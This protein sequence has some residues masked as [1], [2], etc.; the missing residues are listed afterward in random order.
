MEMA[1]FRIWNKARTGA[2]IKADM[3]RILTG[4]EAGLTAYYTFAN[5][6]RDITGHGN[7]GIFMYKE[8]FVATM[9]VLAGQVLNTEGLTSIANAT[10]KATKGA[11]SYTTT[12][13]TN[14][15]FTFA[16][17]PAGDYVIEVVTNAYYSTQG[18]AKIVI[19]ETTQMTMTGIPQ[20]VVNG[21][22]SG[23]VTQAAIE[24]SRR[25][26]KCRQG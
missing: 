14:G 16:G 6:T 4:S 20:A 1:D 21:I 26:R 9:G 13:D 3:N 19:D 10:V 11:D 18:N 2:E 7:D 23:W 24:S 12:T 17:L 25:R 15:N 5:T 22:R 8:S